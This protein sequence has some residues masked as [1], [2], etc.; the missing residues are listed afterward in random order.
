M[1]YSSLPGFTLSPSAEGKG[2]VRGADRDRLAD[3]HLTLLALRARPL[4]FPPMGGEGQSRALQYNPAQQ[5]AI[6]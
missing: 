5:A 4:P 2:R 6:R 1:N 3:T